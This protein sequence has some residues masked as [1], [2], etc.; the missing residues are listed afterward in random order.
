MD[1]SSRRRATPKLRQPIFV[2][3]S[4]AIRAARRPVDRRRKGRENPK[5]GAPPF[6][7]SHAIR[8][9]DIG[10][11]SGRARVRFVLFMRRDHEKGEENIAEK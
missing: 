5:V 8:C 7:P 11:A 9:G 4:D 2:A 6:D 1:S 10:E 3:R